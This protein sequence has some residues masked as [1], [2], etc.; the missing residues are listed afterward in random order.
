MRV[1]A[2]L[3][4][5]GRCI[6]T[7][8]PFLPRTTK[9]V[10]EARSTKLPRELSRVFASVNGKGTV[11]ELISKIGGSRRPLPARP[12]PVGDRRVHPH[13]FGPDYDPSKALYVTQP[14]AIQP[15]PPKP[16]HSEE[17]LDF[18]SAK[19]VAKVNAEATERGKAESEARSRARNR[20]SRRRQSHCTS[21]SGETRPA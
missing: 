16:E 7:R 2:H 10:R 21:G 8:I 18:T 6:I 14:I 19:G 13:I 1:P 5:V 3:K 9:G 12:G 4:K 17:E 11:A 15:A 20:R